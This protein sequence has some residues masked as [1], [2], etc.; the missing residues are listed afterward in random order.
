VNE[1]K[2]LDYEKALA[3]AAQVPLDP[4]KVSGKTLVKNSAVTIR[5]LSL[6]KGREIAA[7]SADGDA[8]AVAL[9]GEGMFPMN[10]EVHECRAGEALLIPANMPHSVYAK[11]NFK[12]L[13]II[14]HPAQQN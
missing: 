3:L 12:M 8:L 6:P 11:E 10:G 14:V 9:E 7:H 2:N 4:E 13:L 1:I 5:L